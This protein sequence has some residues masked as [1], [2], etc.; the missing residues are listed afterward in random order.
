MKSSK[1]KFLTTKLQ[2]KKIID[3]NRVFF[4]NTEIYFS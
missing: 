3:F 1:Q 2:N 4:M